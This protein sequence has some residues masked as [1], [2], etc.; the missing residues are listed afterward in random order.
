MYEQMRDMIFAFIHQYAV[1]GIL[2]AAIL[3]L[4]VLHCM[5]RQIRKLNRSLGL[6]TAKVQQYFDIILR[7]EEEEEEPAER[8]AVHIKE[9]PVHY[10]PREED[11]RL[12]RGEREMLLS[13]RNDRTA[14]PAR[15]ERTDRT[16][17]KKSKDQEEVL[18]AVLQEYFS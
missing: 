2:L 6:V 14:R 15:A 13:D 3:G 9:Q 10:T 11:F 18:E 8:E 12:T 16:D 17:R 5:Y 4:V 1:W 7:E